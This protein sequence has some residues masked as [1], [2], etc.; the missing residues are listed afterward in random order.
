MICITLN[1]TQGLVDPTSIR[2]L[3]TRR[4]QYRVRVWCQK[5]EAGM[6]WECCY[7]YHQLRYGVYLDNRYEVNKSRAKQGMKSLM[8]RKEANFLG[9]GMQCSQTFIRRIK[10]WKAMALKNNEVMEAGKEQ[11]R[12]W[13]QTTRKKTKNPRKVLQFDSSRS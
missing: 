11:R 12:N 2:T 6:H 1:G 7:S 13:D 5:C 3:A 9:C 10:R 4:M 8:S